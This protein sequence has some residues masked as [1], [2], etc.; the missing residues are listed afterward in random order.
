MILTVTPNPAWDVTYSV[1]QL[2]PGA[3]HRVRT[4]TA[5]AGGKGLNV[6]RLLCDRGVATLVVA[7]VGGPFAALMAEDL[8]A[9]GIAH[10]FVAVAA[11]TRM[12]VAV[13][14]AG[15][16]R[17]GATLFNEPGRTIRS[18]EWAQVLDRVDTRLDEATVLV[19]SGSL[20]AGIDP[21]VSGYLVETATRHGRAAVVDT[22]G[23]GLCHAAEAG[24]AVVKP[25]AEEL[26]DATG[27]DDPM[28][29][30]RQLRAGGAGA[31]VVSLGADG[32]I[33]LS[34]DGAWWARPP[35]TVIGNA[36]GAGDAA[37]A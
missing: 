4:V 8:S 32:M 2:V 18:A 26:R 33:A 11:P 28:T 27:A 14:A 34:D 1:D 20:P 19:C 12:T 7:P 5:Q 21:R 25:T 29:G 9:S 22:S 16:D 30:A 36:T 24:A 23:P 10:D 31:V 35:F 13:V 6:S 17:R 15:P 3:S 37:T